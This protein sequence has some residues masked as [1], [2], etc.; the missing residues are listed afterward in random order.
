MKIAPLPSR[1]LPKTIATPSLVAHI[2]TSKFCDAVPFY[3]QEK[4][5]A[6]IGVEIS[7]T[8]MCNWGHE[9]GTG[10]RWPHR[11]LGAAYP[12][13]SDD[14]NGPKR[15]SRCSKNSIAPRRRSPTCGSSAAGIP[16]SPASDTSM[17]RLVRAGSPP[18]SWGS[19]KG[20]VQSDGYKGVR[21]LG[22]AQW[23]RSPGLLGPCTTEVRRGGECQQT[24]Q[25]CEAQE[26]GEPRGE[27]REAH[28]AAVQ[29]REIL[30][31]QGAWP[32][33]SS[34]KAGRNS[35]SPFWTSSRR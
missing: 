1:L 35:S 28:S 4:Q 2:L 18:S 6:R 11:G 15:P 16:A 13:R 9:G 26:E 17:H 3:R 25:G 7:R 27:D 30:E 19:T 29:G 31:I 5:F 32:I 21:F 24:R 10:R 20:V 8:T 34:S 33:P 14:R 12:F 22:P 23:H